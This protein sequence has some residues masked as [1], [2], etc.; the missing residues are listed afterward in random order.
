MGFG[1]RGPDVTLKERLE[2]RLTS[3]TESAF[4][5]MVAE[6]GSSLSGVNEAELTALREQARQV[7]RDKV[8]SKV[9]DPEWRYDKGT[10]RFRNRPLVTVAL[11][12]AGVLGAITGK[13]LYGA[14]KDGS[15]P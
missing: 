10:G 7:G 9:D 12:I 1:R 15:L 3:A 14:F 11:T 8:Y 4:D 6:R 13:I 2:P 5:A